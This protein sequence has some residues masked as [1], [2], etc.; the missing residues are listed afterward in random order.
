MSV[1]KRRVMDVSVEKYPI[2]FVGGAAKQTD[3]T[4]KTNFLWYYPLSNEVKIE[5]GERT[6]YFEGLRRVIIAPRDSVTKGYYYSDQTQS[7]TRSQPN[8]RNLN[9]FFRSEYW[10]SLTDK[11]FKCIHFSSIL[12]PTLQIEIDFD[13]VLPGHK[14]YT[15]SMAFNKSTKKPDMN[16]IEEQHRLKD[17]LFEVHSNIHF[18]DRVNKLQ[19]LNI[20]L[21]EL[22]E[23]MR[24]NAFTGILHP[25]V[26][27]KSPYH[28]LPPE[29]LHKY[30]L[31]HFSIPQ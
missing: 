6:H 8:S 20:K 21:N 2:E 19:G 3:S 11:E 15:I 22:E 26:G 13:L 17:E 24:Y 12:L 16:L 1:R 23:H 25:R 7:Q 9:D 30:V 29:L 18:P 10:K 14:A 27:L 4:T 31:P 28:G 5:F